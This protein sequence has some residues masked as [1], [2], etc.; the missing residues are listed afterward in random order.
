MNY[1]KCCPNCH[2]TQISTA[3]D[4]NN[5]GEINVNHRK[6]NADDDDI[7]EFNINVN[8]DNLHYLFH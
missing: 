7:S 2:H 1:G 8:S 4:D 6:H 3:E 5:Q